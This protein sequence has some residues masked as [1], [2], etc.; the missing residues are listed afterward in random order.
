[1]TAVDEIARWAAHG[2]PA[3]VALRLDFANVSRS[4]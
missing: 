3:D 2:S 1:V 4:D